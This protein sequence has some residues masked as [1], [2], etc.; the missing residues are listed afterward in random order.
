VDEDNIFNWFLEYI[1]KNN[2]NINEDFETVLN[3]INENKDFKE[4]VKEKYVLH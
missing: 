1:T 4:F 2:I 3:F